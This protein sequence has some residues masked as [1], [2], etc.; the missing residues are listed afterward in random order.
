MSEESVEFEG[1]VVVRETGA[2]ILVSGIEDGED[3][4]IPKSQIHPDSEVWKDG[5]EGTLIITRWIAEQKGLI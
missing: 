5:D 4:W 1:A 2:A 3:V